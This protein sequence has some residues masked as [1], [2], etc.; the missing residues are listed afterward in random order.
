MPRHLLL[1]T[2]YPRSVVNGYLD[3]PLHRTATAECLVAFR[4]FFTGD[5]STLREMGRYSCGQQ[6]SYRTEPTSTSSD[7]IC[8]AT[9]ATPRISVSKP[10]VPVRNMRS[11]GPWHGNVGPACRP[12]VTTGG[13]YDLG[14]SGVR[15][16]TKG[17]PTSGNLPEVPLLWVPTFF[18]STGSP[19]FLLYVKIQHEHKLKLKKEI[20]K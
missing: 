9:R 18:K 14:I 5:P 11:Q 6:Y 13:F 7:P 16:I 8:Q 19:Y 20:N 4:E 3:P 10:T 2:R 17:P 15:Q 1:F 12:S